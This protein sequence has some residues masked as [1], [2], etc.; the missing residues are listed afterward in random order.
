V[1]IV[2]AS[3]NTSRQIEQIAF[4]ESEWFILLEVQEVSQSWCA[5][6]LWWYWF[7]PGAIPTG[8]ARAKPSPGHVGPQLTRGGWSRN[9]I[10]G[11]EYRGHNAGCE[12][13]RCD[14]HQS[15][16]MCS[17]LQS[18]TQMSNSYA[19]KT[20]DQKKDVWLA[21]CCFQNEAGKNISGVPFMW[22]SLGINNR[23]SPKSSLSAR[24]VMWP[25]GDAVPHQAMCA[26]LKTGWE[27]NM[28][29]LWNTHQFETNPEPFLTV[30]QGVGA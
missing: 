2:I 12:P 3:V 17:R 13:V 23:A 6:T 19:L 18:T 26:L 15:W 5:Q 25:P 22:C 11:R 4:G 29:C 16:E 21:A 14:D 27:F 9:H 1:H 7:A 20:L 24:G 30:L 28:S 10:R 8:F